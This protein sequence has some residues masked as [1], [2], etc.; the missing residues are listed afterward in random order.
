MSRRI[1]GRYRVEDAPMPIDL[2]ERR[3]ILRRTT[4]DQ[5]SPGA[6]AGF[7]AAA[8]VRAE[9]EKVEQSNAELNERNRTF[10]SKH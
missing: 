10:W 4:L 1:P 3:P 8:R 5:H 9:S 7:A 6:R 2:R